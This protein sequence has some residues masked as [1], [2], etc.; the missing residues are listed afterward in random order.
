MDCTSR[1]VPIVSPGCPIRLVIPEVAHMM[2]NILTSGT[3]L[4]RIIL[5]LLLLFVAAAC[6]KNSDN[7]NSNKNTHKTPNINVSATAL[8]FGSVVKGNTSATQTL[9]V[10]NTGT[11][12]LTLGTLGAITAPFLQ[13]GGTCSSNQVLAPSASCTL[14]I[15]VSP[16]STGSVSISLAIP[17]DD[18]NAGN[19]NGQNNVLVM[20]KAFGVLG[21]A[22][23]TVSGAI[24]VAANTN[25]DS[26]INDG[27]ATPV[28]N[29]TLATAQQIANPVTLGGYVSN[30]SDRVDYFSVDLAQGQIITL[31]I[32]DTAGGA[33]NLDMY[34]YD[35]SQVSATTPVPSVSSASNT[36][37]TESVIVP[38]SGAYYIGVVATSGASDYALFVNT[39]ATTASQSVSALALTTADY[40]PGEVIVRFK[41]LPPGTTKDE[42]RYRAKAVGMQVKAGAGRRE[43]LMQV[44][45]GAARATTFTALGIQQQLSAQ[46]LSNPVQQLKL[47]TLSVVNALRK[48]NDV[49][50]ATPNYIVHATMVPN[51]TYYSKQWDM[52]NIN[53]PQ[54][55]GVTTGSG[56]NGKDIIVAVIDTGVLLNHPDLQGQ[57]VPGYDFIRSG[58]SAS[59]HEHDFPENPPP[60]DNFDIDSNPDDPGGSFHGTHVSGTIAAASNNKK[61]VAGIGWNVKIMP[62][63]VLGVD[64]SGTDYDV[65][66]ALKFAA[67]LANDSTKL[68]V[69]KADVVNMS[70]GR[71]CATS[72]STLTPTLAAVRNAGVIM[73]AAAGND[74]SI[75]CNYPASY[76]GVV[77]VSAVDANNALAPYS[78]SGPTIDVTAPGGDAID[79]RSG[80][81]GHYDIYSTVGMVSVSAGTIQYTYTYYAGTSMATP[82]VAGVAALM[83]AMDPGMTPADFDTFLQSGTITTDLGATGRDDKYGYG[84]ID[85]YKAVNVAYAA[86]NGSPPTIAPVAAASPVSLNFPYDLSSLTFTLSNGGVGTLNV[87]NVTNNSAG[88]WLTITPTNIDATG[89][90]TYTASVDRIGLSSTTNTYN[91]TITI[92][93][94]ANTTLSI[95]VTMQLNN[96]VISDSAGYL[97]GLL[98]KTDDLSKTITMQIGEPVNGVYTF[99]FANG[100]APTPGDYY[101]VAGNDNNNDGYICGMGEACGGYPTLGSLNVISI[102]GDGSA[103]S[104][105]NFEVGYS[106]ITPATTSGGV[107]LPVSAR[108]FAYQ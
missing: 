88:G 31:S 77:S 26:D 55:W 46:Q 40:V 59:D 3:C 1:Y 92:T 24:T 104:G 42:R 64:G 60:N 107:V 83:K 91:A 75:S 101:L 97:K 95:P 22:S 13:L 72:D 106:N 45:A 96:I 43:M 15:S 20:L 47:D 81:D 7:N 84:L 90:G 18:P 27:L 9:T 41:D 63:R 10:K 62:I 48:R 33:N 44:G 70:F 8:D 65:I 17:S 76:D 2:T 56:S 79:P 108:G 105:K 87:T 37:A 61:G 74:P 39:A 50:S 30:N 69:Q 35:A 23:S 93:S 4:K 99:R 98:M 29:N 38:A 103:L 66:Q 89:L 14:N 32:A 28:P 25:T 51:D 16:S 94:N 11:V 73:I 6:T 68:P 67:G 100:D 71:P 36:L 54:A 53:M 12:D 82:H 102:I 52:V 78:S 57:L 85:A 5:T 86:A 80:G 21:T 58:A 19:A 34:L 49:V